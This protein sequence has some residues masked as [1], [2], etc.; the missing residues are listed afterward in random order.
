MPVRGQFADAVSGAELRRA[1][2]SG[3][4]DIARK[5]VVPHKIADLFGELQGRR[6]AERRQVSRTNPS[7]TAREIVRTDTRFQERGELA[8]HAVSR[9]FGQSVE[10]GGAVVDAQQEKRDP[11]VP[12]RS[13]SPPA[14]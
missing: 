13:G 14:K 10:E 7:A 12:L 5:R 1:E 3:D 9:P 2:R 6:S 8:E 11:A 4:P